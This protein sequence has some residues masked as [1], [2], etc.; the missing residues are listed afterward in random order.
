[1]SKHP[2]D[3]QHIHPSSHTR[4]TQTDTQQLDL[5]LCAFDVVEALILIRDF[6]YRSGWQV[7]RQGFDEIIDSLIAATPNVEA[8]TD[9]LDD[10]QPV[11]VMHE[12]VLRLL[13]GADEN[14]RALKALWSRIENILHQSASLKRQKSGLVLCCPMIC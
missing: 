11:L 1:M 13:E 2:H 4:L 8:L 5:E 14:A 10:I 3:P 6:D 12:N 7:D 9:C